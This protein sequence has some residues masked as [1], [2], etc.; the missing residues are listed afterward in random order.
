MKFKLSDLSKAAPNL[1][2]YQI[3][4]IRRLRSEMHPQLIKYQQFLRKWSFGKKCQSFTNFFM[5][6]IDME[7]VENWLSQFQGYNEETPPSYK[8]VGLPLPFSHC[9]ELGQFCFIQRHLQKDFWDAVY[10]IDMIKE[11]LVLRKEVNFVVFTLIY[12]LDI[13]LGIFCINQTKVRV[14]LITISCR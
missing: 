1:I 5:Y 3:Q 8:Q 10:V 2:A 14:S 9:L 11:I 12:Q 4:S 6:L 7:I 13:S